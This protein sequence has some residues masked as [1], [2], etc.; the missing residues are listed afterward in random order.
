[1]SQGFSHTAPAHQTLSVKYLSNIIALIHRDFC[2][3]W[4]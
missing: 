3:H 4:I 1:M 2:N